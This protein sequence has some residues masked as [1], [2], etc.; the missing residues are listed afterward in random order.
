MS[1]KDYYRL[2][3]HVLV[4]L[5]PFHFANYFQLFRFPIYID[6]SSRSFSSF[7][8]WVVTPFDAMSVLCSLTLFS[9]FFMFSIALDDVFSQ[10]VLVELSGTGA[11]GGKTK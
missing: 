4:A 6:F 5:L 9:T 2:I 3:W 11:G 10:V 8:N 1:F 7:F